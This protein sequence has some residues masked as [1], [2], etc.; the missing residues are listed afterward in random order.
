METTGVDTNP[1]RELW[2]GQAMDADR[3]L[4]R[5]SGRALPRAI[6]RAAIGLGLFGIGLGLAE[7][8]APRRFNR[9]IG[10]GDNRRARKVTR[11]LGL[12]ELAN[13]FAVLGRLRPGPWLWARVAGDVLDLGLLANAVRGRRARV[14]RIAGAIGAVLGATV[15]DAYTASRSSGRSAARLAGPVRRAITVAST[16]DAAYRFWRDLGNLPKFM[17]RIE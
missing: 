16:P 3:N 4:E 12:R 17:E 14:S 6:G 8:F 13:S 2:R 11:A 15:V 7:L 1:G 9:L 10:V 5:G